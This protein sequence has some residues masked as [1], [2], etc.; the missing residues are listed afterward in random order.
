MGW[1]FES[2]RMSFRTSEYKDTWNQLASTAE[3]A[4]MHV[5]GNTDEAELKTSTDISMGLLRQTV[6]IQ[7]GDTFLEI[8]CGVGRVATQLAP[9][10]HRWIGCDV[11]PNML[12]F[13]ATRLAGM[14][15]VELVPISGFDLQP[16]PDASVDVVYCTV[17]FMHLEE[18]DRYAYVKEAYRVLKPGGRFFCDN[19]NLE[20]E[21]GWSVFLAS[22]SFT[23]GSRPAHLS[24][25]STV[26]ELAC[27]LRK[28]GFQN[29]Q[30]TCPGVWVIAWGVK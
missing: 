16:I 30:T 23:P 15:N 5:A 20:S 19:A 3:S 18:W 25:C 1:R 21:V 9:L 24:R 17:V 14:G 8:G 22:A 28:A 2:H 4:L 6:G 29:V 7:P 11:S 12:S 27:Y 13:A 26:P 10:V